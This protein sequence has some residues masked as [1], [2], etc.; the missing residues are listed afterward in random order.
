M[1]RGVGGII[2]GGIGAAHGSESARIC[3]KLHG[4]CSLSLSH[5]A[6][7]PANVRGTCYH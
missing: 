2:R 1:E 7:N 6:R 5:P 3:G 4:K